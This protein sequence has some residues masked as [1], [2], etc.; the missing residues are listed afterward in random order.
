[1]LIIL[2]AIYLLVR[3]FVIFLFLLFKIKP[4]Q[5]LMEANIISENI[6]RALAKFG[7][8]LKAY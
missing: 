7:F 5:Q 3:I 6:E 4:K 2:A 1:M 8:I